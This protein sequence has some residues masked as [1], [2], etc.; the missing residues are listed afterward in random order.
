[1]SM[2][3]AASAC[4][5]VV[6]PATAIGLLCRWIARVA[7][8]ESAAWL[9]AGIERQRAGVDERQLGIA[10]GLAARKLGRADLAL[11]AEELSVAQ[12]LRPGWQP[13]VWTADEAARVA[14]LL[15]THHSDDQ[16]FAARL[17]RLCV[18][19]EVTEH[20]AYLKGFAIFPAGAALHGR[21][22]EG[23]RSSIASVFQAIACHNPYPS[24]YFDEAAWNQM[25]VKCVFVGAPIGAIVGLDARRN[26]EL[27]QMLRDFV[28]E[29]HAAGRPLPE[30]VHRFIEG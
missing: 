8:V 19:A 6:D 7:S 12:R 14:L 30:A 1:M 20:I 9:E 5:P 23:V 22:R 16:S 17:E 24:D 18:T 10:L 2:T 29:R 11:P 3:A 28:A 21:A 27:I 13:Q 4:T 25:V 26:V 15:A